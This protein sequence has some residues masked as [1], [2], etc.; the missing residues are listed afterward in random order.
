MRRTIPTHYFVSEVLRQKKLA[1]AK[2]EAS[3]YYTFANTADCAGILIFLPS[4]SALPPN[5]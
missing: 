5:E 3:F 2:A 1:T 4:A